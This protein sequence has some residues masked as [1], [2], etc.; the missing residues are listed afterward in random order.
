MLFLLNRLVVF[1]FGVC[2]ISYDALLYLKIHSSYILT[3]C[4]KMTT[5]YL[6]VKNYCMSKV[7]IPVGRIILELPAGMLDD[8]K[9]D[10][11]GTAIREVSLYMRKYNVM[12]NDVSMYVYLILFCQGHVIT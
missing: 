5:L 6:P 7:R 8:D 10:F 2:R 3:H 4:I 9:G 11:L 1:H 12:F